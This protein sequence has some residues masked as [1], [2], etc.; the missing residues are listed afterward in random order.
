[1]RIH[2]AKVLELTRRI[3]CFSNCFPP[4]G[5]GAPLNSLD[6]LTHVQTHLHTVL[7]M[8]GQGDRQ[9]RHTVVAVS[10]NLDSHAL[11]LLKNKIE[12]YHRP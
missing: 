9:A 6:G 2:V 7:G 1:M 12:K 4:E 10:Q 3:T 8:H 11:V 5:L